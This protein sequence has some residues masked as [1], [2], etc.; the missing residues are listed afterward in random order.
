MSP[1]RRTKHATIAEGTFPVQNGKALFSVTGT[2]TTEPKCV[3]PMTL[4]YTH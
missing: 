4:Q 1:G 2:G 3:P